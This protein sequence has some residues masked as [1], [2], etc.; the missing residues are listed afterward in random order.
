MLTSDGALPKKKI[1]VFFKKLE[2][3]SGRWIIT[4]YL[5][6]FGKEVENQVIKC[7]VLI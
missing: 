5:K 1:C 6:V 2:K 7:Y 3:I 4:L